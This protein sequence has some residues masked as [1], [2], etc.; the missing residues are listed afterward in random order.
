MEKISFK[1]AVDSDYYFNNAKAFFLNK[2]N[3][4]Q[5]VSLEELDI[6][7]K[8]LKINWNFDITAIRESHG[9]FGLS[10]EDQEV[11]SLLEIDL[12]T[13]PEGLLLSGDSYEQFNLKFQLEDIKTEVKEDTHFFNADFCPSNLSFTV[14]EI[15]QVD[16]ENFIIV[17]SDSCLEF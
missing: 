11:E 9:N 1:S 3:Q 7:I 8:K 2:D 10:C 13:L 12:E 14:K 5:E 6:S 4:L 17:V 15:K 16:K